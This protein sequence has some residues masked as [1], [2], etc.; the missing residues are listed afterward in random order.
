MGLERSI[1]HVFAS[2]GNLEGTFDNCKLIYA[3]DSDTIGY[4]SPVTTGCPSMDILLRSAL[5]STDKT[6][7]TNCIEST[8]LH[9]VS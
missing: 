5:A 3:S 2:D 6:M 4:S 8:I 9:P 7:D 1:L